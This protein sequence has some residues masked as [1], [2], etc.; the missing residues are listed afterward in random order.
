MLRDQL[1]LFTAEEIREHEIFGVTTIINICSNYLT[2]LDIKDIFKL[3]PSESEL[4]EIGKEAVDYEDIEEFKKALNIINR[5]DGDGDG[6]DYNYFVYI[7]K[8]PNNDKCFLCDKFEMNDLF[9]R[10]L[11]IVSKRRTIHVK[12]IISNTIED[13]L[14][15]PSDSYIIAGKH[16]KLIKVILKNG[17]IDTGVALD[18]AVMANDLNLINI[19]FKEKNC[20]LDKG[21]IGLG[22]RYKNI[23]ILRYLYGNWNQ[24]F[25]MDDLLQAIKTGNKEIVKYIIKEM[26]TIDKERFINDIIRCGEL[27]ILKISNIVS[28]KTH[29]KYIELAITEKRINIAIYILKNITSITSYIVKVIIK[30]G[31]AKILQYVIE[32]YNFDTYKRKTNMENVVPI[33]YINYIVNENNTEL[34]QVLIKTK[35]TTTNTMYNKALKSKSYPV[36]KNI[37]QIQKEFTKHDVRLLKNILGSYSKI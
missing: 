20:E 29:D 13:N 14:G 28:E 11:N 17:E 31:E 7:T 2:L 33:E 10:K 9:W 36:L 6:G 37:I 19:L 30:R 4:W 24:R 1:A 27:E 22:I 21:T 35:T 34:F 26:K 12:H 15:I 16:K 18:Y 25:K 3:A 8:C 32:N 23:E 5:N